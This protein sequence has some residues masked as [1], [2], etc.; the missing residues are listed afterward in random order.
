MTSTAISAQGSVLAISGTAGAAK[1]ITAIALGF[2]TIL[3]SAAH[4][5]A[6]GDIETLAGL[7]G[8]DA[9]LLNG[10]TVVI[11]N[12]T[13]NTFAVDVD[14]TGKTIA[15]AGTATP[16]TWTPIGNLLTFKAFD[17]QANEIDKTN[18]SSVAKEFMLG[19][20]DF[21]HFTFD[22]DKDFTDPGQLACDT[23]KRAGT[24]KNFKL[25]LPNA[26]TATFAGYV[27]NTPLDGGV[28]QVLKTTGVSIR[29]TGD[30]VYA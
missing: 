29:I 28:D 30:V 12:I 27:K 18:L 5:F 17:G 8:A 25:T 26:R 24:L 14:T 7:T 16:V 19:L 6:N 15:A 13:T 2:P 22:V 21:G 11:K 3:T 23:A 20:Q 1:N 4:G 10:Q 9:A